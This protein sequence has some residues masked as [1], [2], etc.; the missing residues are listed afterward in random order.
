M[1]RQKRRRGERPHLFSGNPTSSM[2]RPK[3]RE[4]IASLRRKPHLFF[5]FCTWAKK[6][7]ERGGDRVPSPETP[8]L[9]LLLYLGKKKRERERRRSHHLFAGNPASSSPSILGQEKREEEIASS[10]RRKPHFFY[11]WAKGEEGRICCVET[12]LFNQPRVVRIGA[13]KG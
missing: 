6:K 1:L 4:G 2:I 12:P 3:R 9:L 10:L 5:S 8:P 11:T 13:T 7:R